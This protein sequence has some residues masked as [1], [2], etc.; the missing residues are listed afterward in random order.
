MREAL[1][2]IIAAAL[3]LS[4]W[5]ALGAFLGFMDTLKTH[6]DRKDIID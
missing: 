5:S 1:L 6:W 2:A 4:A 3:A